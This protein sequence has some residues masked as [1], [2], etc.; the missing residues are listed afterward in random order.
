PDDD[1]LRLVFAD[2]LEERGN[3]RAEFVR[4]QCQL[5]HLS[6]DDSRRNEL[7]LREQRM[8][9]EYEKD[10][11]GPLAEFVTHAI[12]RRGF[13]EEL[14]LSGEEFLA[15]AS[16]IYRLAPAIDVQIRNI[17]GIDTLVALAHSPHLTHVRFL[18]LSAEHLGDGG[19]RV[20]IDS[21]YLGRLTG[22]NLSCIN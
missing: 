21:P 2:W 22:L 19:V 18:D 6:S 3:P 17:G 9:D 8:L 15:H 20:L 11:L 14:I 5:A 10:W 13:L 1:T 7:L 4:V 16:A 12:F